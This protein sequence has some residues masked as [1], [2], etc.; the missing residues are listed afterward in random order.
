MPS[1]IKKV[2]DGYKKKLT[3]REN[4]ITEDDPKFIR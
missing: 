3:S 4:I 2:L 1:N